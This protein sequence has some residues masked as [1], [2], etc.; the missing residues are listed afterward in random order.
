MSHVGH[1]DKLTLE[2]WFIYTLKM[3]FGLLS[4][5]LL[6]TFFGYLS[7]S[8]VKVGNFYT[9]SNLVKKPEYNDSIVVVQKPENADGRVQVLMADDECLRNFLWGQDYD[10]CMR[11]ILIKSENLTPVDWNKPAERPLD[12]IMAL[13]IKGIFSS[14]V[15]R[16][17]TA[18]ETETLDRIVLIIRAMCLDNAR[19]LSLPEVLQ[20]L[21][22][23]GA[24]VNQRFDHHAMVYVCE[25]YEPLRRTIEYLWD[26]ISVW[27]R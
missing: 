22:L 18:T 1:E 15:P 24:W 14:Y 12:E 16:E 7:A 4:L 13:A 11:S 26:G 17:V 10:K 20:K 25:S 23:L 2:P 6:C 9:I 21:R 27:L 3:N 5:T 19:A 8:D